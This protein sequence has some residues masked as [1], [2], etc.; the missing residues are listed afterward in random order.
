MRGLPKLGDSHTLGVAMNDFRFIPHSWIHGSVCHTIMHK[1]R[2]FALGQIPGSG[3]M[4]SSSN[5]SSHGP[6]FAV[7]CN[8][9]DGDCG[10]PSYPFISSRPSHCP[11]AHRACT[12]QKGRVRL[13]WHPT[14]QL[15]WCH[16]IHL[17]KD[18]A[19]SRHPN[20]RFRSVP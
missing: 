2:M 6:W 14:Y 9:N 7:T 19:S 15:G 3:H 8:I 11:L 18:R 16:R 17:I 12:L 4:H 13:L 10:D 5:Y 20:Q 1:I